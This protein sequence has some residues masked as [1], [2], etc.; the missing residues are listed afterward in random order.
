MEVST[1]VPTELLVDQVWGFYSE[2]L[3][4][5]YPM[6]PEDDVWEC[7]I[8]ITYRFTINEIHENG[9]VSGYSV[10]RDGMAYGGVR[11]G[12]ELLNDPNWIYLYTESDK[13]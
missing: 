8:K 5:E 4:L 6:P 11:V 10:Y 7:D 9:N 3:E 12:K 1:E 2:E 13:E